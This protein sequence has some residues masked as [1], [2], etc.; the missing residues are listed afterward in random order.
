MKD[1]RKKNSARTS[2]NSSK[3]SDQVKPNH[4]P[5]PIP[6]IPRTGLIYCLGAKVELFGSFANTFT[7]A[8][9]DIDCCVTDPSS[10]STDLQQSG[11]PE[12]LQKE[13]DSRGTPSL[14]PFSTL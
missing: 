13:L 9:S 5:H 11:L 2:S 12:Q 4:T 14:P 7:I 10:T 3:D 8:N 1:A 6:P